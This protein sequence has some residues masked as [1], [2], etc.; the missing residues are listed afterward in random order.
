MTTEKPPY[1]LNLALSITFPLVILFSIMFLANEFSLLLQATGLFLL[2]F[3]FIIF[4]Y[5]TK[6]S[7]ANGV[8]RLSLFLVIICMFGFG[9]TFVFPNLNY[10]IFTNFKL[11]WLIGLL[12]II[13]LSI[14]ILKGKNFEGKK[15][16]FIEN[17]NSIQS[18]VTLIKWWTIS[19]CLFVCFYFLLNILFAGQLGSLIFLINAVITVI[20][21]LIIANYHLNGKINPL[22]AKEKNELLFWFGV[23]L[24]GTPFMIF[25]F[26][27]ANLF[28]LFP[29]VIGL[30]LIFNVT[31]TKESFQLFFRS[32]TIPSILVILASFLFSSGFFRANAYIATGENGQ[33][34]KELIFK[35]D[36][37]KEQMGNLYREMQRKGRLS[38]YINPKFDIDI[39]NRP[40]IWRKPELNLE[41]K[42]SYELINP[43]YADS[44]RYFKPGRYVLKSGNV[45][46]A[47]AESFKISVDK[48][49]HQYFEL[50]RKIEIHLKGTADS[51]QIVNNI[52]YEG[53]YDNFYR[54]GK[55]EFNTENDNLEFKLKK[56]DT[57]D[58]NIELASLRALSV[59]KFIDEEILINAQRDYYYTAFADK[60]N[61][62]GEFRKVEIIL[63]IFNVIPLKD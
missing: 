61:A 25:W 54:Y 28:A 59:R 17:E 27:S 9:F 63:K 22:F 1:K 16:Q 37:I 40:S 14:Q 49:L 7:K 30:T 24:V 31:T 47:I 45:A 39:I 36:L 60:K 12:T 8:F 26:P 34:A 38:K 2:N 10:F 15:W 44:V 13:Y 56:G 42:Y 6:L 18:G 19:V 33:N 41:L 11:G 53:E 46:H 51:L 5:S 43:I 50:D 32:V 29:L 52:I 35:R 62:G 58:D 55:I 23:F 20:A 48:Y 4:G 57:V 21:I 3:S